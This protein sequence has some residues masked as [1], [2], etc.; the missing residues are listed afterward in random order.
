DLISRLEHYQDLEPELFNKAIHF[1][2][3]NVI[4]MVQRHAISGQALIRTNSH[5]LEN[6]H[7]VDMIMDVL[8]ERGYHVM[9]DDRVRETPVKVN[10]ET[11]DIILEKRH[12]YMF[13]VR[14]PKHIIQPLDQKI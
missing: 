9:F 8:S 10:P 14:F 13:S 4:P 1:V 2:N 6:Q 7:L 5:E 12:N 3:E 11:W